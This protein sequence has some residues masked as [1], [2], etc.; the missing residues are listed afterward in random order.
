[1]MKRFGKIVMSSALLTA[2]FLNADIP[3]PYA[4]VHPLPQTPYYVQDAYIY[5][6]L[7]NTHNS[8][9]IIDVESEDGSVARYLAQ[10]A[11]NLPSIQKIYSV[12]MWQSN[13]RSQKHLFQRFLSNVTY[14]NTAELIVPIRMN[15]H[16]ATESLNIQADFISLV[17]ANDQQTI[18]NDILGWYPHLSNEGVMCGNN[19]YE[20]SV[21]IG[22][23]KAAM[24]LG[25]SVQVNSNV[26]YFVKGS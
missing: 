5:Y 9:I 26:W 8:A 17:G 11:S 12:N 19:W 13:D 22:V 6:S 18:Y 2:A 20:P 10:Q 1:M 7:V 25:T 3:E 15:S 14:E 16:E 21:Q 23:T 24:M 4:S